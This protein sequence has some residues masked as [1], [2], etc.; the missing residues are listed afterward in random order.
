[1]ETALLAPTFGT[2]DAAG[3]PVTP[4]RPGSATA[5]GPAAG[6]LFPALSWSPPRG[7]APA[8]AG[9]SR[10]AHAGPPGPCRVVRSEPP[11]DL[12][13]G[14]KRYRDPDVVGIG[15]MGRVY[16]ALD[17]W[18]GHWVALKFLVEGRHQGQPLREARLQGSVDHPNVLPVLDAGTLHGYPWFAMPYLEGQT[19]KSL[20]RELDLEHAVG[21]MVEV[22]RTVEAIHQRGI[23]HCDLNPRNILLAGSPRGVLR[24]WVIDFGIAQE[25]ARPSTL[26]PMRVIGTPSYMAPEQALG[27]HH[28]IDHRTDVYALGATLY[29]LATGHRPFAADTCEAVL[30]KAIREEPQPIHELNADVPD[31]LE[32][33]VL[34]CLEKAPDDRY[35]YRRPPRHRARVLPRRA[36][37]TSRTYSWMPPSVCARASRARASSSSGR[38]CFSRASSRT[39]RPVFQDSLAISA[40]RS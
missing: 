12:F 17:P 32:R 31:R 26:D 20:R 8:G 11:P 24:P 29:E 35:P 25:V 7:V 28:R 6:P 27:R 23:V 33:I 9:A 22:A 15:G 38:T 10:C 19:L 36:L 4:R 21:L 3:R 1:M 30:T 16:R 18:T 13:R 2:H 14:W 34:R 40:A 37:I 39:G 5:A